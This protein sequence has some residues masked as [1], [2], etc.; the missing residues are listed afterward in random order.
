[1]CH[2]KLEA[3]SASLHKG[4]TVL[5]RILSDR[6]Q[7]PLAELMADLSIPASTLHRLTAALID[8]GLIART[9]HGR[10]E[11]GFQLANA[12]EGVSAGAQLAKISRPVLKTMARSTGATAHLGILEADM[13]TYLVKETIPSSSGSG[14]AP[15]AREGGQ[16]EAYCSGVGKV[17]LA[18]LE[19]SERKKYL[20]SGPFVA[21]THNT[22]TAPDELEQA[23]NQVLENG[24]AIDDRE[25]ADDL[26]C[27]SVPVR[28]RGNKV[29]AA[30]SL[31]FATR[32]PAMENLA[33]HVQHLRSCAEK[34]GAGLPGAM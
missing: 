29:I 2:P 9:A 24:F 27:I 14:T 33:S 10:Y 25:V 20:S 34:I 28:T 23:L 5:N 11:A 7:T 26:F 22:I 8:Q 15:F 19:T 12:M 21:L 16:L 18:H 32:N 13:V 6:G 4:L 1:M 3:G 31:S 17:L 30:I